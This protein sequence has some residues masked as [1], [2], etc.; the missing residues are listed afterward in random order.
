MTGDIETIKNAIFLILV[1]GF[2]VV[3]IYIIFWLCDRY[4]KK[5]E[6]KIT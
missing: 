4:E 1:V 2:H 5:K 6:N 3:M